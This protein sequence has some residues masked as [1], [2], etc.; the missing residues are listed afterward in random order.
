LNHTSLVEFKDRLG[1]KENSYYMQRFCGVI[2]V[3]F[4][5]PFP[6]F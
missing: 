1:E 6:C 5:G 2:F 3:R 4:I